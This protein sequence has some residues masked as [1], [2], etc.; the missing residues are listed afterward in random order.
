MSGVPTDATVQILA[1]DTF[2]CTLNLADFFDG[3]EYEGS[4]KEPDVT[5]KR[6]P[7][8]TWE[9]VGKSKVTLTAHDVESLEK[10]IEKDYLSR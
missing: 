5:L 6:L 2:G 8:G 1:G 4:E 7:N 10:A 3:G 9:V